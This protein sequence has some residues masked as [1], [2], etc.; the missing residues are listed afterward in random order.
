MHPVNIHNLIP[1]Y[2]CWTQP[3]VHA[4]VWHTMNV[5][6]VHFSIKRENKEY[7]QNISLTA[8]IFTARHFDI[9]STYIRS[10]WIRAT[11][12][13][14]STVVPEVSI[15]INVNKYSFW[16]QNNWCCCYLI[17]LIAEVPTL[18]GK[19]MYEQVLHLLS[20]LFGES[21]LHWNVEYHLLADKRYSVGLAQ[22][23]LQPVWLSN[24]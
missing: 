23:L 13:V 12:S 5:L 3:I 14:I 15:C 6:H 22:Q 4:H 2:F 21:V 24:K 16:D 8:T 17:I 18:R 10:L 20:A 1:I 9:I 11:C 19:T 7:H